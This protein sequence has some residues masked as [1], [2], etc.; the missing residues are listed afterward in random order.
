MARRKKA[1]T[2]YEELASAIEELIENRSLLPGE[3]IPSVRAMR[4]KTGASFSTILQAFALL[5]NR[6]LVEAR[7]QSGFYVRPRPRERASLGARA[8]VAPGGAPKKKIDEF[9]AESFSRSMNDRNVVQLAELSP[10]RELLPTKQMLSILARMCR[11]G[12]GEIL[13]FESPQGAAELRRQIAKRNLY[14]I[15][16]VSPEEIITTSGG[17][18]SWNLCLRATAKPGD[19]VL[20][21]SPTYFGLFDIVEGLAMKPVEIPPHPTQGVCLESFERALGQERVG[22]C[23]ILPGFESPFGTLMPPETRRRVVELAAAAEVPIIEENVYA[24]LYFGPKPLPPLKSFDETGNVLYCSSFSKT[25]SPG[26][27]LGWIAPGR[28]RQDLLRVRFLSTISAA[29]LVQKSIA[30]FLAAGGYDRHLR[31]MRR[32]LKAQADAYAR[33]IRRAF[34]E[35][36]RVVTPSGGH[37]MWIGLPAG[38]DSLALYRRALDED[39][40]IGP[41]PLFSNAWQYHDWVRISFALPCNAKVQRALRHLGQWTSELTPAPERAAGARARIPRSPAR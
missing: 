9:I 24:D 26:F 1:I 20:V 7:P 16:P 38:T 8:G 19:A 2:R 14:S 31:F 36:T 35:G 33:V 25:I 30:T 29:S 21:T 32:T 17:Y 39:I 10:S 22:A 13:L 23:L 3:K 5:E 15:G 37:A 11:E 6:G 27:R 4:E 12:D 34:P 41:G 28:F 40:V 18:E